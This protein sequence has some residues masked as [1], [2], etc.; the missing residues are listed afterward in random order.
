ML[1]HDEVLKGVEGCWVLEIIEPLGEVNPLRV[2][3]FLVG[4]FE[5]FTGCPAEFA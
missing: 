5:F 1:V 3:A 2:E 4:V